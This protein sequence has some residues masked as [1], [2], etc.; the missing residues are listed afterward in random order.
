MVRSWTQISTD[1]LL[2]AGGAGHKFQAGCDE[3]E[4]VSCVHHLLLSRALIR[5]MAPSMTRIMFGNF[6]GRTSRAT[7][8]SGRTRVAV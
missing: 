1:F 8:H 3:S 5:R 2:W 7:F 4:V 6:V